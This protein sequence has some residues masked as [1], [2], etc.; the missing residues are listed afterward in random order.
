[1]KNNT[2]CKCFSLACN[3]GL[4]R[5]V[6]ARSRAV[7]GSSGQHFDGP[8]SGHVLE[9][10][11]GFVESYSRPTVCSVRSCQQ[12]NVCLLLCPVQFG[13]RFGRIRIKFHPCWINHAQLRSSSAACASSE[14][15]LRRIGKGRVTGQKFKSGSNSG[16]DYCKY[17]PPTAPKIRMNT[18]TLGENGEQKSDAADSRPPTMVVARQPKQLI[19]TLASGPA[20]SDKH[21]LTWM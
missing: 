10:R 6:S 21:T 15:R 1:M 2:F 7:N 3:H 14:K 19:S 17:I 20:T 5:T 11:P 16:L 8:V 13:L 9:L 18:V 4:I 12:T